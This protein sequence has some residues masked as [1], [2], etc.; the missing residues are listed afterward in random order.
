MLMLVTLRAILNLNFACV[1]APD[2]P[3]LPVENS[4]KQQT[5]DSNAK[6]ILYIRQ[7]RVNPT[8]CILYAFQLAI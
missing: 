6:E 1:S 3:K 2:G 4:G 8:K 7:A 5:A